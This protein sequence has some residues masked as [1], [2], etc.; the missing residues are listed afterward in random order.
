MTTTIGEGSLLTGSQGS[1]WLRQ[2]LGG[3]RYG[4]VW[5]ADSGPP[6]GG[7]TAQTGHVVVKIAHADLDSRARMDFRS[8]VDVLFALDQAMT[9]MQLKPDEHGLV[10]RALDYSFEGQPLFFVQTLA[11]GLPVDRLRREHGPLSEV[12]GLT[13]ISQFCRV[14]EAL[15]QGLDRSYLDFQPQNIFWDEAAGNITVIDWNLLTKEGDLRIRDDL[16]AAAAELYR[17]LMGVNPPRTYSARLLAEP[18]EQW[19][20]LSLGTK[21]ILIKAFHVNPKQRFESANALRS[22]MERVIG[23]WDQCAQ[24]P[25]RFL[26]IISSLLPDRIGPGA[27]QPP[28]EQDRP[29]LLRAA[30]MLDV[31]RRAASD[32]FRSPQFQDLEDLLK[33]WYTG[34]DALERGITFFGAIDIDSSEHEFQQ[35]VEE[36]WD[37]F[38]ALSAA[39]WRQLARAHRYAVQALKQ[40]FDAE[41]A[42]QALELAE[43]SRFALAMQ[44]LER[45]QAGAANQPLAVFAAEMR[46]RV[47]LAEADRQEKEADYQQAAASATQAVEAFDQLPPEYADLVQWELGD[48]KERSNQ[49]DERARSAASLE[50]V[51]QQIEGAFQRG[52]Q[53]GFQE[54]EN[55]LDRQPGHPELVRQGEHQVQKLLDQAEYDQAQDLSGMLLDYGPAQP[56]RNRLASLHWLAAGL[57]RMR[58]AWRER[59][60][61]RIAQA[62]ADVRP[63]P[64]ADALVDQFGVQ[65][66]GEAIQRGDY[67]A[68]KAAFA[69]LGRDGRIQHKDALQALKTKREQALATDQQRIRNLLTQ[70]DH[71]ISQDAVWDADW[72]RRAQRTA[73]DLEKM[74]KHLA[75][76]ECENAQAWLERAGQDLESRLNGIELAR[77]DFEASR[78]RLLDQLT[79]LLD[80][81]LASGRIGRTDLRPAYQMRMLALVRGAASDLLALDNGSAEQTEAWSRL[82]RQADRRLDLLRRETES[83]AAA[84]EAAPAQEDTGGGEV[85]AIA[86]ATQPAPVRWAEVPDKPGRRRFRL[87]V[88]LVSLCVVT[89]LG[90]FLCVLPWVRGLVDLPREA[91]ATPRTRL[92]TPPPSET[93]VAVVVSPVGSLAPSPT[94]EEPT[95]TPVPP[96]PT[97]APTATPL[98]TPT[99]QLP[100]PRFDFPGAEQ[101]LPVL[102]WQVQFSLPVSA[103][104]ELS[105]AVAAD[106]SQDE[107]T[108]D[109]LAPA[110]SPSDEPADPDTGQPVYVYRWQQEPASVPDLPDGDYVLRARWTGSGADEVDDNAEISTPL[111]IERGNALSAKAGRDEEVDTEGVYLLTRPDGT[112]NA[113]N[114]PG[115]LKPPN[116]LEGIPQG[117]GIDLLGRVVD[118]DGEEWCHFEVGNPVVNTVQENCS[119]IRAW[120]L[121]RYLDLGGVQVG[122]IPLLEPGQATPV[123]E[124][125]TRDQATFAT[126]PWQLQFN[127]PISGRV[128]LV[129]EAPEIDSTQALTVW[130]RDVSDLDSNATVEHSIHAQAPLT[131]IQFSSEAPLES[132]SPL[133][134]NYR[135]VWQRRADELQALPD[136]SY[137][138]RVGVLPPD[139][140]KEIQTTLLRIPF[141]I[142]TNLVASGQVAG[143]SQLYARPEE[144]SETIQAC[145]NGLETGTGVQVLG[146][147]IAA[148]GDESAAQ[149]CLLRVEGE[150]AQNACAWAAGWSL[151]TGLGLEPTV[152]DAV[153]MIVP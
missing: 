123:F 82:R 31:A 12:I 142:D 148:P 136:G 78:Q 79:P 15:H 58:Q 95:A 25:E 145:V 147:A 117:S 34:R 130:L 101:V 67:Q 132:T 73:T 126:M 106:E 140:A 118:Q 125:P 105:L 144:N 87:V 76:I 4:D 100:E 7:Q 112:V 89:V 77:A 57:Q 41:T 93:E 91:T 60:W 75:V 66:F 26:G 85:P 113:S 72:S 51:G 46:L 83:T 121:C 17:N 64:G 1:Y 36:A 131:L 24:Q 20:T 56:N 111:R 55:A 143:P 115:N 8:E 47:L 81:D 5:L 71:L 153:P 104:V 86:E 103:S 109:I 53:S 149:W 110:L 21:N 65:R 70:A 84:E 74:R 152:L 61:Q 6:D 135:Y 127:L 133:R 92:V 88:G 119:E 13:I 80:L 128:A 139:G 37:P 44:V 52:F 62:A 137:A 68:G 19:E 14:L 18:R 116:C 42:V 40:T 122:A 23:Y 96:T 54:L 97:A 27:G 38:T 99:L 39:R 90:A 108:P 32:E 94:E 124:F 98:P 29:S 120:N 107:I 16:D 129:L 102:P 30:A 49:L 134:A 48:P 22:D 28:A 2:R 43:A 63:H 50:R 33:S 150:D 45:L 59:D 3:G 151:C 10:P 35:A 114:P 69:L 146:R 9:A 11:Q 138:L 141:R